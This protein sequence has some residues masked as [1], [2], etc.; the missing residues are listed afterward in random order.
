M[1]VTN[2]PEPVGPHDVM[3]YAP[4]QL[5]EEPKQRSAVADDIR[6]LRENR[7]ETVG[8][9]ISALVPLDPHAISEARALVREMERRGTLFG[10]AGRPV[11][12]AIGVSAIIALL[13]AILIP[14]SRQP[15]ST[16][17]LAA[18]AQPFTAAP[19]QQHQ[20]EG[21]P[22]P[23]LTE[24]RSLLASGDTA[25]AAERKQPEKESDKVLQR[26][27]Q[28]RQKVNPGEAAQ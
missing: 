22:K 7:P 17:L 21:A 12:V 25:Q 13:F 14:T 15:N 3:Y 19:A 28:W 16:R 5:R 26:F 18:A 1:S 8:R 24:F 27:L 11:P 4:R 9:P 10:V 20:S 6:A 23:A 2:E